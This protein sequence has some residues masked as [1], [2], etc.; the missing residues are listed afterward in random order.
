MISRNVLTAALKM[1]D[2]NL[3]DWKMCDLRIDSGS[4]VMSDE[5]AIDFWRNG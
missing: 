3:T 1:Q 4:K 5:L 2:W